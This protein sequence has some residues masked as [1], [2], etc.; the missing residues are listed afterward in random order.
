MA[1]VKLDLRSKT[2]SDLQQFGETH[3]EKLEGNPHFPT[4]DPTSEN[5]ANALAIYTSR[6]DDADKAYATWLEL[7]SFKNKARE[8]FMLALTK[9]GNYVEN[10]SNGDAA[11][12]LSAGFEVRD[13]NRLS[14]DLEAPQYLRATQ[15]DHNGEADLTWDPVK[16]ARSYL[17]ECRLEESDVWQ[18]AKITTRSKATI[19]FLQS[20]KTYAFRVKAVGPKGESEWSDIATKLIV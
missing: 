6:L 20:T 18:Q 12:I 14:S 2:D 9:R 19:A 11:I 3:R 4:P 17:I 1:Q 10:A 15:G 5:Y 13:E 8:D 16:S 7:V